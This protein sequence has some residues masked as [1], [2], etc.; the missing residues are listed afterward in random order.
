[1]LLYCFQSGEI[2]VVD[3]VDNKGVARFGKDTDGTSKGHKDIVT[4]LYF[5]K[6]KNVLISR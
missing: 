2:A 4:K 6:K 1:M 3:L 5:S